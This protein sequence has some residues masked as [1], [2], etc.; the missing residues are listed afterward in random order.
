MH[1]AVPYGPV[2]QQVDAPVLHWPH[3]DLSRLQSAFVTHNSSVSAFCCAPKLLKRISGLISNLFSTDSSVTTSIEFNQ[4]L[5]FQLSECDASGI[6]AFGIF[7]RIYNIYSCCHQCGW[8]Q[9]YSLWNIKSLWQ[10]RSTL[11]DGVSLHIQMRYV[12]DKMNFAIQTFMQNL[13]PSLELRC[14]GTQVNVHTVLIFFV[15]AFLSPPKNVHWITVHQLY[16]T[17]WT[18]CFMSGCMIFPYHFPSVN[19]K[20]QINSA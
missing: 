16:S 10:F 17:S 19:K 4:V 20:R 13:S 18:Q 3:R 15:P 1:P 9:T 7:K 12:K 2:L 5:L 14:S 6:N 11:G 8:R